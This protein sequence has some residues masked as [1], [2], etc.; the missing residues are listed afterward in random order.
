MSARFVF[1]SICLTLFL[2]VAPASGQPGDGGPRIGEIRVLALDVFS[3]EEAAQ[4]WLYRTADAVRVQTRPSVIREFLLFHEGDPYDPALLAE[5]ERN[6]RSLPF[7]KSASVA[8][9]AE[10]DGVVDVAVVTQDSWTTE[11]GISVGGKGG[12]TTYGFDLKEKDFLGTGRL[13]SI[14]HDKGTERST[15]LFEYMDPYMFG[16]YWAGNVRYADNS[17]GEEQRVEVARPFASFLDRRSADFLVDHLTQNDRLFENGDTSA[18]FRQHH[19]EALAQYGWAIEASEAEARRVS[20]GFDALED[21]FAL[22]PTSPTDV[23][24]ADRRFRFLTVGLSEVANDFLKV[25]FVDLDSR[26]ED[27]NLGRSISAELGVSPRFFGTPRT[28]ERLRLSAS[29]GWRVDPSS[30]VL[31][32]LGWEMRWD[33]SPA[34]ELLSGTVLYVRKFGDLVPLQTF[35]SRLLFN[36]GWRVD[37]DVQFFA[38]AQ[39]GLRGYRLDAFEGDK[40]IVWNAEQ[41]IFGGKEL[42]QLFS[43]GAAVFFDAG[44]VAEPGRP[45]H[46]TEV[47]SD[48][49]VGLR[50]GITRAATNTI[51]RLDAAYPLNADAHGRRGILVTF[52]SG[53]AF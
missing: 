39:N 7:L 32:T 10:H 42:L 14:A 23:V 40:R 49:G 21:T 15:T 41:R 45:L 1:P 47:K 12:A 13:L 50:I 29:E 24:P 17:D 9:S 31:A 33:G 53:Q 5:T 46:W 20:V 30:F 19:V 51:L 27:F 22:L 2:G 8:A 44:A 38:D 43:P 6:L 28:T 34:N 36:I 26:F 3:P 25:N 37:R 52:S 18:R 4:G 35:V 11:P 16:P 48:A